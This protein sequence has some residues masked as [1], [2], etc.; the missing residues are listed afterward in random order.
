VVTMRA[1]RSWGNDGFLLRQ[2]DNTD[3]QKTTDDGSK[4]NREN[5]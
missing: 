3:I 4:N 2:P 5:S 1:M